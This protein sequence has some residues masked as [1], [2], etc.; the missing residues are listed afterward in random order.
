MAVRYGAKVAGAL[1]LL[2][3]A[4]VLAGW[5][6]RIVHRGLQR[7]KFDLTLTK[8]FANIVRY[9]VLIVGL[10][11]CFGV[12]GVDVTSFAA[13]LAAAGFAIGLAFQSSL[14]NFSAGI[15]LLAFRPFKVGDVVTLAGY[16]GMI[17][18]IELFTTCLDTSDNRRII[19]PNSKI[20][21][22]TIENISFH[23]TRRVD[24]SVA[25]EYAADLD[26]TRRTLETVAQG[27]DA[28][29]PGKDAQIVLVELGDSAVRWQLRV[30][31]K[32]EDYGPTKELVTRN[33]K[34]ALEKADVGVPFPR[35]DLHLAGVFRSLLAGAAGERS[36]ASATRSLDRQHVSSLGAKRSL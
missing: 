18:E 14:S 25:T 6:H 4:W 36:E 32:A 33:V 5:A 19:I 7:A 28:K 12:F 9:A 34:I 24:V 1:A 29:L 16:T 27:I 30:W 20:F 11:F 31:V 3:A 2:F 23:E 10:L 35:M 22:S 8:F 17:N 21:D 26:L 13:V 15:M